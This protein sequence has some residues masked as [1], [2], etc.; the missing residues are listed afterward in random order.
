MPAIQGTNK[1]GQ[2]KKN[3]KE[4]QM[5]LYSSDTNP[6]SLSKVVATVIALAVIFLVALLAGYLASRLN[7]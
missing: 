4:D 7:V 3:K 1:K 5:S 6:L 2:E